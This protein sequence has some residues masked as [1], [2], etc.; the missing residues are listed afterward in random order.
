M[1]LAAAGETRALTALLDP[2]YISLHTGDPGTS[3]ANEVSGGSYARKSCAFT[4]SGSNPTLAKNGSAVQFAQ[5][6]ADWGT[7]THFGIWDALSAGNYL[8]GTNV[9]VAKDI[10]NGDVA[11]YEANALVISTDD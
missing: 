4:L 1:G 11:R 3:G 6:T 10:L 2:V 5:A 8:G 9:D 7:I